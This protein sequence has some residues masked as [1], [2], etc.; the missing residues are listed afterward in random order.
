MMFRSVTNVCR[1]LLKFLK[2]GCKRLQTPTSVQPYVGSVFFFGGPRGH[3]QNSLIQPA[4]LDN[5]LISK[6]L[7]GYYSSMLSAFES[8]FDEKLNI[9]GLQRHQ[10]PFFLLQVLKKNRTDITKSII[11][12]PGVLLKWEE[13]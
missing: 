2:S 11:L 3:I 7:N 9:V 6:L 10:L 5:L 13:K 4:E 1:Y 12:S 8:P